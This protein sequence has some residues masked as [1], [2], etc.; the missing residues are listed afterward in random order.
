MRIKNSKKFKKMKFCLKI[1]IKKIEKKIKQDK[2][3]ENYI[4]KNSIRRK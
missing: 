4:I 3:L 2:M 1:E